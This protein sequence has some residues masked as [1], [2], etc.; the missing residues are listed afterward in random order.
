MRDGS[1]DLVYIAPERLTL[2]ALPSIFWRARRSRSS[3]STRPIASRNGATTSGRT[4]SPSRCCTSAFPTC[5][6]SRSPPPPMPRPARHRGAPQPRRGPHLRRGLRPPEHPLPR[7]RQARAPRRSSSPSSRRSIAGDAGIV[8]CRSRDKVEEVA[9]WLS[10]KGRAALPYHAGLESH[11]ARAAS[12]PVPE[13]GGRGDRRHRR[14]R[15]G[16]RQAQRALR[17]A[18]RR[19][20][21]PRG[22]LPGDRPRRPRR[23]ARRCLDDLRHGRC[24]RALGH[25]GGLRPAGG[26]EAHRAL[27]S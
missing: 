24:D 11:R 7:R 2:P 25:A 15:H 6:A 21:E 10:D 13:G 12:G 26:P 19:A 22:L 3:P 9:R 4:I 23:T 5:R 8:Y 27:T 1:L 17:R 18:S 16:D 14:L 20:Q